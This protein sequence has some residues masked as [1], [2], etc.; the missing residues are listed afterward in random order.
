MGGRRRLVRNFVWI[1][2]SVTELA[3]V[4]LEDTMRWLSATDIVGPIEG[5]VRGEESSSIIS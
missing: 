3:H 1:C 5:D 4:F 2:S